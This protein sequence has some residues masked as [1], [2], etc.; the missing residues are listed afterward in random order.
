MPGMGE[1]G[2]STYTY[3]MSS[4]HWVAVEELNLFWGSHMNY[5]GDIH[6]Y[7]HIHPLW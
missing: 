7:I 5:Y 6:V 2:P 4:Y 1:V 3:K